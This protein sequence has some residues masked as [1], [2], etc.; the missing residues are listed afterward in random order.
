DTP[1]QTKSTRLEVTAIAKKH[2]IEILELKPET[3]II[4]FKQQPDSA[5]LAES[6]IVKTGLDFLRPDQAI[7]V[8]ETS[9]R[10]YNQ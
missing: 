2:Y 10:I 3:V 4:R 5:L 7:S 9:T 6:R 1:V 8:V